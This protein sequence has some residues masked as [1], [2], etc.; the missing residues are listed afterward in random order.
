MR[1][2]AVKTLVSNVHRTSGS[3]E[4]TVK[5]NAPVGRSASAPFSKIFGSR[6]ITYEIPESDMPAKHFKSG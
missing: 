6:I 4:V 3:R 2:R 1:Q 5:P